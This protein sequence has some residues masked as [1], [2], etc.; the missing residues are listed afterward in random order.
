MAD[1]KK[2]E[3]KCPRC[4]AVAHVHGRGPCAEGA[5]ESEH[6][7]GFLCHCEAKGNDGPEV[8]A[9][10]HGMVESNKCHNAQCSHC[11][12]AGTSPANALDYMLGAAIDPTKLK[13]WAK[14]AYEAG[15]VP[16]PNWKQNETQEK[17]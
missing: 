7:A 2:T 11:G 8:K 1:E 6:C 9:F 17:T 4:R 13:G 14:K 16:P 15:W 10:L 5:P 12:W 3:W